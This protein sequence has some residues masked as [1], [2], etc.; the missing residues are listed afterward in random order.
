MQMVAR[1]REDIIKARGVKPT[2]SPNLNTLATVEA[3]DVKR[4]LFIGVGCQVTTC[5][6]SHDA[7]ILCSKI[8]HWRSQQALAYCTTRP[9]VHGCCHAID[10][11]ANLHV[12]GCVSPLAC[13]V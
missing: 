5:S 10:S 12:N 6:A 4:L 11:A 8:L 13:R 9:A 2:L 7:C 3:L 1:C